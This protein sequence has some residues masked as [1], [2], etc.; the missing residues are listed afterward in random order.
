M[1]LEAINNN[2]EM[3]SLEHRK[4]VATETAIRI[5]WRRVGC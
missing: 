5:G 1:K 2:F 4:S 3:R